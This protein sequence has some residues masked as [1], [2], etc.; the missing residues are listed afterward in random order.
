MF[1]QWTVPRDPIAFDA[2]FFL[3]VFNCFS[4]R[5]LKVTKTNVCFFIEENVYVFYAKLIS[6]RL[7]KF[8]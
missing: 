2:I 6:G 1:I 5:G 8:S 4:I 7:L 3:M